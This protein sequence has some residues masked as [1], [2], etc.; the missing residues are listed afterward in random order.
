MITNTFN[1]PTEDGTPTSWQDLYHPGY[2]SEYIM[3]RDSYK[4]AFSIMIASV[5]ERPRQRRYLSLGELPSL[6][7]SVYYRYAIWRLLH[8]D[9][10]K[11]IQIPDIIL[12]FADQKDPNGYLYHKGLFYCISSIEMFLP[13][14]NE[15]FNRQDAWII[16]DDA[17][18]T[19]MT[20]SMLVIYS[21]G[22][23]QNN[24]IIGA[25]KF[26]KSKNCKV[27]SSTLDVG[28]DIPRYSL[29]PWNFSANPT[30]KRRIHAYAKRRRLS[31]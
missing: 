30:S 22:N 2:P 9:G 5:N 10:T 4:R 28:R 21:P 17:P 26:F 15:Y 25:K 7:K 1:F 8:P 24:E 19:Y 20:C 12:V 3:I 18:V 31:R 23:F 11:V 6:G 27:F 13:F 14:T 29:S 16:C